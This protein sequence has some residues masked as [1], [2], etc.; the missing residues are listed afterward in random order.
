MSNHL[1]IPILSPVPDSIRKGQQ[2]LIITSRCFHKENFRIGQ[3]FCNIA[4]SWLYHIHVI[5]MELI[6]LLLIEDIHFDGA[7]SDK[8]ILIVPQVHVSLLRRKG[9]IMADTYF[10]AL[11]QDVI[12]CLW[13]RKLPAQ[14]H[15]F[16]FGESVPDIL[17]RNGFHTID[18][19][20]QTKLRIKTDSNKQFGDFMHGDTAGR[21]ENHPP[22]PL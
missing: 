18:L 12:D 10:Q 4:H 17:S 19:I 22:L 13:L 8:V 16:L 6:L 20:S 2:L 3:S 21:T 15:S 5:L 7:T 11:S 14:I 1:F 9:L